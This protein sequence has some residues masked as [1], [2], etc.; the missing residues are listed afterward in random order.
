[1]RTLTFSAFVG[2]LVACSS[3]PPSAPPTAEATGAA[4]SSLTEVDGLKVQIQ[5][6]TYSGD[7]CPAG[8]LAGAG[9]SPS[10]FTTDAFTLVTSASTIE[11][12]AAPVA[13]LCQFA[14]DLQIPAGY[15][16]GIPVA[17]TRGF[18]EGDGHILLGTEYSWTGGSGARSSVTDLTGKNADYLVTDELHD[19]PWSPTCGDS[20]VAHLV[21]NVAAAVIGAD[22]L[23][24]YDSLDAG[25]A[26]RDGLDFRRCGDPEPLQAP[27]GQAGEYCGGM[28]ARACTAGLDCEY[29]LERGL[30]DRVEGKCIDPNEKLPPQP[31]QSACGGVRGITCQDGL[32][33]MHSSQ[34]AKDEEHTGLCTPSV[35]GAGDWCEGVPEIPCAAGLVCNGSFC[36]PPKK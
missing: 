27:P 18:V 14:I 5:R 9:D 12:Q 25:L 31:S 4:R 36:A 24:T 35:G 29:A 30:E 11:G 7:L 32:T 16:M 15:Q 17:R 1:M 20:H 34:K 2:F 23:F 33:C 26:Y 8:T 21:V 28:H 13:K 6:I 10:D 3:A 22:T 19:G